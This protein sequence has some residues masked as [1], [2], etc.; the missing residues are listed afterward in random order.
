VKISPGMHLT[1][2]MHKARG[3]LIRTHLLARDGKVAELMLS[4]DFTVLPP[5]GADRLA[6]ALH[7]AKL[8]QDALTEAAAAG[9]KAL[10]L[11]MPGVEPADI[12]TAVMGAVETAG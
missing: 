7:G 5:D 10:K 8:D 6:E 2:S 12:A 1:E 4:G 3:G 11:E 9:L